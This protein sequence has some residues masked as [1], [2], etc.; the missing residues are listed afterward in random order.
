[1]SCLKNSV[2][3][4]LLLM[5][6]VGSLWA[7]MTTGSVCAQSTNPSDQMIPGYLVISDA[8]TNVKHIHAHGQDQIVYN[9][10]EDYPANN[11]LRTI[12]LQLET[13]GWKPLKEDFLNPGQPSSH[14][15]GW[16]YFVDESK[17][18]T[19]SVRGWLANWENE[20]HDVVTY[21]LEYR[22]KEDL[23]SSTKNL[24]TLRVIGV[25]IPAAL[26]EQL[27]EVVKDN[28]RD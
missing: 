24:H 26:K 11:V 3:R 13:L 23:C 20:S 7:F 5:V 27:K 1:M 22:C 25:Y 18:P 28:S 15:R 6:L 2:S 12:A 9:V 8:A 14:V 21:A 10:E 17:Y 19:T 4:P 16:E